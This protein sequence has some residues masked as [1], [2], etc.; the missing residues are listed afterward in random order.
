MRYF[1]YS[2]YDSIYVNYGPNYIGFLFYVNNQTKI[3]CVKGVEESQEKGRC[4]G[5]LLMKSITNTQC[6]RGF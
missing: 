3:F 1:Q 4:C 6:S 5:T 2:E